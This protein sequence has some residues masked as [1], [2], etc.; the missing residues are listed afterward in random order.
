MGEKVGEKVGKKT[1]E[2]VG[3]CLGEIDKLKL[4]LGVLIVV[5][6]AHFSYIFA[7]LK[8]K[9][10]YSLTVCSFDI[11]FFFERNINLKEI[12]E[13]KFKKQRKK[14]IYFNMGN[15]YKNLNWLKNLQ[16]CCVFYIYLLSQN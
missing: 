9:K 11:H 10:K 15:S 1:G 4:C 16:I 8:K 13:K 14:Y 3:E 12:K 7:G 5:E 2:K 6:S